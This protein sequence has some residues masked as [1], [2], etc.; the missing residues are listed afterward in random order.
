MFDLFHRGGL[1]KSSRASIGF[2]LA[3]GLEDTEQYN[4]AYEVLKEANE[5]RKSDFSFDISAEWERFDNLKSWLE[6]VCSC[7]PHSATS[8]PRPI[9]IVGMPRSGTT[10]VEQI[11][12]AHPLVLARG[13]LSYLPKTIQKTSSENG[14][15]D[16]FSNLYEV[17]N[18]YLQ[19]INDTYTEYL[20]QAREDILYST[21]KLP[22]N[23]RWIGLIRKSMPESVIIHCERDIPDIALSIYKSYFT[24]AG[25]PYAYDLINISEYYKF[26]HSVM[27]YWNKNSDNNIYTLKYESL[28]HN[29]QDHIRDLLLHIGLP[30][31]DECLSPQKHVRPVSTLSAF[32]VREEINNRSLGLWK[33]YPAE[34]QKKITD[35]FQVQP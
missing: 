8:G 15:E 25:I 17:D 24:S 29:P 6:T 20:P 33:K 27:G 16:N 32:Q 9:F 13:E 34:F 3:K 35:L 2:A 19:V 21:D 1:D 22:E 14:I 10:L 4:E 23:F 30:M 18:E 5:L 31:A 7:A 26:Y 12:S 28:V 11:L